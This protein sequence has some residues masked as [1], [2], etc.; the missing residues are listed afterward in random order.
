MPLPLGADVGSWRLLGS[1]GVT[2]A[3]RTTPEELHLRLPIVVVEE[4]FVSDVD[5]Q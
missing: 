3:H 4:Q 5:G 2:A 1:L